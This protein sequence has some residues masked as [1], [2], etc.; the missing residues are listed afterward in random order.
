MIDLPPLSGEVNLRARAARA[1]PAPRHA[2]HPQ[3]HALRGRH[4]RRGARAR[5]DLDAPAADGPR[6]PLRVAARGAWLHERQHLAGARRR[7]RQRAARRRDR[8]ARPPAAR[9]RRAA[10]ASSTAPRSRRRCCCTCTRSRTPSATEIAAGRPDGAGDDRPRADLDARGHHAPARRHAPDRA[11]RRRARCAG[12]A[13]PARGAG[14]RARGA[15][16][17]GCGPARATACVLRLTERV[18]TYDRML[19]GRTATVERIY[20]DYDDRAHFGV[21]IDDDPGPAADARVGPLPLLLRGRVRADPVPPT[22]E[23]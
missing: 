9:A 14:D 1:R 22:R 5:A 10:A 11:P 23:D 8:A 13:A 6:R 19:D 2:A 3:R 7:R 18:D 16:R 20:V 15:R 17:A 21:T 4:A 12:A